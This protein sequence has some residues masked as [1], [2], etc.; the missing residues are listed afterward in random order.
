MSIFGNK[1]VKKD[2]YGNFAI[3]VHSSKFRKVTKNNFTKQPLCWN[4]INILI[5]CF[6]HAS[7]NF[8]MPEICTHQK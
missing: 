1:Q 7:R 5:N 8:Q 4:V 6:L 2:A 3:H